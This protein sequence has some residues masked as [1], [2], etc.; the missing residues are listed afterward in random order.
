MPHADFVH[1][2][3][4]SSYSMSE[5]AIKA[6]KI[7]AL[8]AEAAMPAVAIADSG[9]LFGAME[10]SQACMAKG[11]Q[12]IIGCQIALTRADNPRLAPD[13]LVLL[14]QNPEGFANLQRLSSAGFLENDPGQVPQV[15]LARL[16]ELSPGLILLTGGSAGPLSR[17][18]A[19]GQMPAARHLLDQLAEA[20]PD[21]LAIE[22]NRF[23]QSFERAVEPGLIQL[24]AALPLVA[25]NHCFFAKR[26]MH[27][28]HD[29]LLCIAEGRTLAERDR[30]R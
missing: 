16:C 24:A 6:D 22:L 30:R 4:H 17:L 10:F 13:R 2:R 12:P 28:A 19:E 25:T 8:A 20:F 5:G 26:D 11:V 14:A 15:P 23:G 3:V 18:L 7:A 9:N 21:R 1:L 27:E 29:A